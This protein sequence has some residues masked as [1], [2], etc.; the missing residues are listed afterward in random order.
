ML[1]LLTRR[2]VF[3]AIWFGGAWIWLTAGTAGAT[4]PFQVLGF[5]FDT[6]G[7]IAFLVGTGLPLAQVWVTKEK[8]TSTQRHFALF[9]LAGITAVLGQWGQALA[10]NQHFAWQACVTSALLTFAI[11]VVSH[12]YVWAHDETAVIPKIRAKQRAKASR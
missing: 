9:V 4:T 1:T 8:W 3:L 10:S 12:N 7:I 11:G 5:T 2:R 6:G